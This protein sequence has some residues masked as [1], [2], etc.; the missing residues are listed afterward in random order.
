M[1]LLRTDMHV[2][3]HCTCCFSVSSGGL[4]PAARR[5]PFKAQ[6]SSTRQLSERRAQC[7]HCARG[8]QGALSVGT[9]SS[10]SPRVAGWVPQVNVPLAV[11]DSRSITGPGECLLCVVLAVN[12]PLETRVHHTYMHALHF[13]FLPSFHLT[14][15]SQLL[16]FC[17][18]CRICLMGSNKLSYLDI[19]NHLNKKCFI[20]FVIDHLRVYFEIFHKFLINVF[21]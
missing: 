5:T 19:T 1:N 18:Y 4:R 14:P 13:N 16:W 17:S 21:D 8:R 6:L 20:F 9:R 2:R 7:T 15:M 11:A 10:A 12:A 3:V